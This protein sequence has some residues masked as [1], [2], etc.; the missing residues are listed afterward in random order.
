[1]AGVLLHDTHRRQRSGGLAELQSGGQKLQ[2]DLKPERLLEAARTGNADA[3]GELLELYRNYLRLV[4]RSL[5][6]SAMRVRFEPSDL[7]QETFLKAHRE[8]G[9]F[10]GRTEPELV[11][12]LRQILVRSLANQVKYHRRQVRNLKRQE[13]LEHL[14]S[15]SSLAIQ[16]SLAS[17]IISPSEHASRREQAVLLAD[18]LNL[19]P[20]DYREAFIRRT[21]EHVP[22]QTIAADMGRS[23]GAVRMLW[24]RAVKRLTQLLE[25]G[26]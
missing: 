15:R 17:S 21:L 6:S 26:P 14:L 7:V 23:V 4:A 11:A 1:L 20:D 12:W 2:D 25:E 8:F 22:F 13:S 16:H 3:R 5:F 19:L 9:Q 18:A 10:A 24:A